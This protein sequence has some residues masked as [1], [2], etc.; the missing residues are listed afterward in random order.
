LLDWIIGFNIVFLDGNFVDF[1]HGKFSFMMEKSRAKKNRIV[2]PSLAK[3]IK[4]L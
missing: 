4:K 2:N 3:T 1:F